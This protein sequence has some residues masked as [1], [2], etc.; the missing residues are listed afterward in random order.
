MHHYYFLA[1]ILVYFVALKCERL[2]P[3]AC[4]LDMLLDVSFFD[5]IKHQQ[6]QQITKSLLVYTDVV[7]THLSISSPGQIAVGICRAFE[8]LN[9]PPLEK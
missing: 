5:A 3:H 2:L 8:L 7:I 9:T 4:T 1:M 6:N